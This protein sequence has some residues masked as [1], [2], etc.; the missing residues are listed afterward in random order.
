MKSIL[1]ILA[2]LFSNLS[3]AL[4]CESQKIVS[5]YKPSYAKL[6]SIKYYKDFKIVNSVNDRFIVKDNKNLNCT[7]KLPVM[8]AHAKR[9]IA[10]STTHLPFLKVFS[11]ENTLIGFQ[12]VNY[13]YDPVLGAQK[14]K[15]I[16]YQMNP[17]ELISLKP[18]LV[19]AYSANLASEKRLKDL[20]A[21]QIPIVLNR[22]FQEQHPLARAE[23]IVFSAVFFSKDREAQKFFKEIEVNYLKIK[24]TK[25]TNMP[26]VLVGDIQNGKWATCGGLSDLAILI[27]DAGGT[28]LLNR[29]NAETQYFSLEEVLTVKNNPQIWL[30]QNTWENKSKINSDSRYNR[31]KKIHAYNNNKLVNTSGFN[32]YWETA[33]SRPDLL[34]GE[35]YGIFHPNPNAKNASIWYKELK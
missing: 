31:F 35:L 6:F 21:L 3:F 27:T 26:V 13:I 1:I 16:N 10:T 33:L 7:T 14:I 5:E 2:A 34:V 24:N 15:N 30:T 18:D 11:L 20:R 4:D 8:S 9:F 32:D 19:M 17:E 12:G 23:W 29:A 25:K 22:D 28:L